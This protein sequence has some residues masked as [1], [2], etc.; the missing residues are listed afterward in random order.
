VLTPGMVAIGTGTPDRLLRRQLIT[1]L[2][3]AATGLG[4]EN[5]EVAISSYNTAVMNV[6]TTTITN[7]YVNR[8]VI[9]NNESHV[10]V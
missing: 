9:V 10:A 4:V 6:N 3:M 7:V 5:G 2:D 1:D 8:T